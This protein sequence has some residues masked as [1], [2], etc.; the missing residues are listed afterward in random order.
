[1]QKMVSREQDPNLESGVTFKL[2][3]ASVICNCPNGLFIEI[4]FAFCLGAQG[5]KNERPTEESM[6]EPA[7][8]R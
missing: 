2:Q 4:K 6:R 3:F 1:M 8:S 5:V 7:R